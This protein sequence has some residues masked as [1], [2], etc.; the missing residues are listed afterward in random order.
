MSKFVDILPSWPTDSLSQ[1]EWISTLKMK[2]DELVGDSLN[3]SYRRIVM[4]ESVTEPIKD[5]WERAFLF[6]IGESLPI[7][8]Y[9]VDLVW[10]HPTTKKVLGVFQIDPATN[11]PELLS[12]NSRGSVVVSDMFV[13]SQFPVSGISNHI[14]A[15]LDSTYVVSGSITLPKTSDLIVSY[16]TQV[17]ILS[18]SGFVGADLL[19]NNEFV[20][21]KFLGLPKFIGLSQ[22][23]YS[24]TLDFFII[25]PDIGAGTHNLE[26]R[27]GYVGNTSVTYNLV[28]NSSNNYSKQT[29]SVMGVTR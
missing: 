13:Q 25:L 17:E 6:Q 4:I 16:S 9:N 1:S 18:G 20:S 28:T 10:V 2:L 12:V 22:I 11:E 5:D 23:D 8:P 21:E 19:L 7:P 15:A 14:S 29:L 27:T 26:V 24:G 3:S